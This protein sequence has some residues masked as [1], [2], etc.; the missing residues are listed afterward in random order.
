[1]RYD[2][3][4]LPEQILVDM[5]N[6][7]NGL[8]LTTDIVSFSL[9]TPASSVSG[10]NTKVVVSAKPGTRVSGE[11]PLYYS[12]LPLDS[13]AAGKNHVFKVEG[14]LTMAQLIPAINERFGINLQSSEYQN[15]QLPVFDQIAGHEQ[16]PFALNASPHSL[17]FIGSVV[18]MLSYLVV[19]LTDLIIDTDLGDITA[20]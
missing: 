3:S 17:V 11:V 9:P 2:L 1:M 14:A 16:M 7:D 13:T 5:I 6:Q 12:R 15:A 8:N 18:L 20:P 19:S 10:R 4:K